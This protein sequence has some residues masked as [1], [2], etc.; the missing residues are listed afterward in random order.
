MTL[1]I[2]SVSN[3]HI[4][5]IDFPAFYEEVFPNLEA[6]KDFYSK[7]DALPPEKNAAKIVLHQAARMV[8]LADQIDTVARGRP[9][10]QILFYLIAAELVAKITFN[11]KSEGE[12]KNY[13]RRFFSEICSDQAKARLGT[14][15]NQTPFGTV[16][17]E[18]AVDLLYRIRCD[19]VH[20]GMYYAFQ[21]PCDKQEFPELVHIN[22]TSFTTNITIRE[23]RR[24][25]LEGAVL[26][27]ER[28]L[29][30]VQDSTPA[31]SS[32]RQEPK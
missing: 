13:V 30:A 25:V 3:A 2:T 7:V 19:V 20:E 23:I 28:L 1:Q 26:A 22:G 4:A 29:E 24:M 21:L 17:L 11:F 31:L 12:S 10:F 8:W 27:S 5:H 9:A 32:Q 15:F 18:E 16:T 14:S 6:A